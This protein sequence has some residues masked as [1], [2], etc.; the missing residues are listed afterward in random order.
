MDS[1]FRVFS[2]LAMNFDGWQRRIKARAVRGPGLP[3]PAQGAEFI[4]S[5]TANRGAGGRLGE[6]G[7]QEGQQ[8]V[9]VD[10]LLED[11]GEA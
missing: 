4:V 1:F 2:R 8:V 7:F 5:W 10:R 9:E 6:L 3:I 11:A